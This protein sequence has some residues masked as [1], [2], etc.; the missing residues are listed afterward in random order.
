MN[1]WSRAEKLTFYA[2]IVAIIGVMAALFV[3]PEFRLMIGLDTQKEK[4]GQTL[5]NTSQTPPQ[6]E[7][8][9][10][11]H[12]TTA[13]PPSNIEV[14]LTGREPTGVKLGYLQPGETGTIRYLSG[15]II[16]NTKNGFTSPIWGV[17][18]EAT[19]ESWIP[20]M[21]YAKDG[22]WT[23]AVFIEMAGRRIPFHEGHYEIKVRNDTSTQQEVRLNFHE[24]IGFYSDNDGDAKFLFRNGL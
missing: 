24:A 8:Q 22:L 9:T 14:V 21:P 4:A 16:S 19:D 7:N 15:K 2:L 20:L 17:P 6:P 10:T 5:Q 18:L 12:S 23:N 13:P 1:G 11:S 3:A